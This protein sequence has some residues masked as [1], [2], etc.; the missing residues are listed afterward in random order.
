MKRI[1]VLSLLL[2]AN[3]SSAFGQGK[4][5]V[6]GAEATNL[7]NVEMQNVSIRIN[8]NGD[9]FIQAPQYQLQ[10][11]DKFIPIDDYQKKNLPPQ[12]NIAQDL[13]VHREPGPLRHGDRKPDEPPPAAIETT[14]GSSAAPSALIPKEGKK[15]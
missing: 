3:G 13:P 10:T 12:P 7:R 2:I 4:F 5:F 1:C 15:P 8:E 6:N 9:I 14:Q 11:S